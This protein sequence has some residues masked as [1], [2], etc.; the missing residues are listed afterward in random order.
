MTLLLGA[1]TAVPVKATTGQKQGTDARPGN[2]P[3]S[4]PL[5]QRVLA[6][7]KGSTRKP[8]CYRL[9]PVALALPVLAPGCTKALKHLLF[10]IRVGGGLFSVG[11]GEGKE[12]DLEFSF[13]SASSD[14][15]FQLCLLFS[16]RE[17]QIHIICKIFE[18]SVVSGKDRPF[19]CIWGFCGGGEKSNV[20]C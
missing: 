13:L 2:S 5:Q 20:S 11:W 10:A 18:M 9:A 17:R 6:E 15:T 4:V 14:C 19:K 3:C 12:S 16:S 8:G 1:G 7:A